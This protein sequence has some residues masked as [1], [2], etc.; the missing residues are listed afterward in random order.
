MKQISAA[1]FALIANS[2][3]INI[4]APPDAYGRNG[5]NFL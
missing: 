2:N 1:V 4:R 3:A 5:E